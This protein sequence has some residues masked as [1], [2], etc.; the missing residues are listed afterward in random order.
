MDTKAESNIVTEKK[1][2]YLQLQLQTKLASFDTN[3]YFRRYLKLMRLNESEFAN[4]YA[5]CG[6]RWD[7]KAIQNCDVREL[8]IALS[9]FEEDRATVLQYDDE[10]MAS[11]V[12]KL[13]IRHRLLIF[14]K[15]NL[16]SHIY[17]NALHL[18]PSNAVTKLFYKS[19]D[20]EIAR[21]IDELNHDEVEELFSFFK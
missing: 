18:L 11:E 14:V 20:Q 6:Y 21:A 1:D 12:H 2:T 7:E 4:L 19:S 15:R 3:I 13:R 10:T 5:L 8:A 9:F 16:N 17:Y